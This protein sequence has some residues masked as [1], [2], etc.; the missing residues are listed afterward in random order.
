[1]NSVTYSSDPRT[2]TETRS[3]PLVKTDA[4]STPRASSSPT[5]SVDREPKS[6]TPIPATTLSLLVIA[7]ASAWA[8]SGN[9]DTCFNVLKYLNDVE[10]W[11]A[12]AINPALKA[13]R[14]IVDKGL[15]TVIHGADFIDDASLALAVGVSPDAFAAWKNTADRTAASALT[16]D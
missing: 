14:E 4:T 9:T 12:G 5:V 8:K 10:G 15:L 6:T 7:T 13:A 11:A 16:K 1:M 2:V 3:E